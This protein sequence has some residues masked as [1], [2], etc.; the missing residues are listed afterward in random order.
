MNRIKQLQSLVKPYYPSSD[1][2]HNWSHIL[3]VTRLAHQMA[4]SEKAQV[5]ITLAS[6]LC[7]DLVN[8]PKNDP[9]RSQASTLS[10]QKALPLLKE[11]GFGE[12]EIKRIQEAIIS[13]SYS[14]NMKPATLE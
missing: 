12:D 6:T 1:P 9:Q 3:R 2:A 11:C 4:I 13:H 5:E 14:K 7:H 8:L 10:A